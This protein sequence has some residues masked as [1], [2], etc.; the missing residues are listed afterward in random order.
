MR[1]RFCDA[2]VLDHR[3]QSRTIGEA[4]REHF[5]NR[6]AKSKFLHA[7]NG[8]RRNQKVVLVEQTEHA[9]RHTGR[10]FRFDAVAIGF[11]PLPETIP[12]FFRD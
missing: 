8:L 11:E 5:G 4:V 9:V 10:S 6:L 1:L 3:F 7:G 12:R 2:S